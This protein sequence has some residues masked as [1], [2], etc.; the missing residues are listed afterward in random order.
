MVTISNFFG[1]KMNSNK[2]IKTIR[3]IAKEMQG[4]LV[5]VPPDISDEA[6]VIPA[7]EY[8]AEQLLNFIADMME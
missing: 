5:T 3:M 7:G 6:T 2:I 4:E 1:K 8:Y